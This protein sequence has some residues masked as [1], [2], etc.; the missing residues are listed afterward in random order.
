MDDGLRHFPPQT[1]WQGK[2]C[3]LEDEGRA[4]VAVD[5]IQSSMLEETFLDVLWETMRSG[6]LCS[7]RLTTPWE[8]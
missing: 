3:V 2:M 4:V 1:L 6:L 8:N 7:K 5:K